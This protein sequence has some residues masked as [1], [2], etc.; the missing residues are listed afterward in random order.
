VVCVTCAQVCLSAVVRRCKSEINGDIADAQY[1][2]FFHIDN[3]C[4]SVSLTSL[5]YQGAARLRLAEDPPSLLHFAPAS[6]CFADMRVQ[7]VARAI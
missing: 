7:V 1:Y 2:L 5:R 6:D 4:K 3:K